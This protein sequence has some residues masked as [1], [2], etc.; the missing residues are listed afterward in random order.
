MIDIH[1]HILPGLDDGSPSMDTSLEMAD[2]AASSGVDTIIMT[3]H[4]NIPGYY[5]NYY[6]LELMHAFHELRKALQEVH[7]PVQV[8]PGMEIYTTEELPRLIAERRLIGLNFSDYLLIDFDFAAHPDWIDAQLN[9]VLATGKKPVIAHPE[10]YDCIQDSPSIAE[11]WLKSGCLLQSN[12]GSFLGSFG[13]RVEMAA[14]ILLEHQMLSFIASDAHRTR[15][16]TPQMYE[17]YHYISREFSEETAHRL[18]QDN[19]MRVCRNA[20]VPQPEFIPF[21]HISYW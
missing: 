19:P 12:K 16:R 6:N 2:I 7:I 13:R 8:L 9:S 20:P 17:I 4:C 11:S 18:M 5:D 14:H 3:P 15:I 21:E 10:R 1:N